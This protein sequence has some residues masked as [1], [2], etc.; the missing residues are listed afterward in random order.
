MSEFI[1]KWKQQQR[2]LLFKSDLI[3]LILL[4][5]TLRNAHQIP[6][7]FIAHP[8][9]HQST[10][11]DA[12]F[13]LLDNFLVL[14][15]RLV[16]LSELISGD[17]KGAFLCVANLLLGFQLRLEIRLRTTKEKKTNGTRNNFT[18]I[19][20]LA[21]FLSNV[22]IQLNQIISHYLLLVCWSQLLQTP[23]HLLAQ[24]IDFHPLLLVS[25]IQLA[26]ITLQTIIIGTHRI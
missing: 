3:C 9:H 14:L 8:H 21:V 6:L 23:G 19:N 16:V 2:S 11:F 10:P 26:E 20:E 4:D 5:A 12:L 22:M 15:D 1:M 17:L 7:I 18:S 25:A 13:K 24:L